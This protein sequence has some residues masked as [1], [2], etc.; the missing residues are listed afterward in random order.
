M[1]F[2]QVLRPGEVC[3]STIYFSIN[4]FS[5][6]K[7]FKTLQDTVSHKCKKTA[8]KLLIFLDARKINRQMSNNT[9]LMCV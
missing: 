9:A 1:K 5:I 4:I 7:I 8:W 2:M 6:L 3:L